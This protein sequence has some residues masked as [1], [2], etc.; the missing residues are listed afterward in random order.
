M[1]LE[2]RS[3]RAANEC[4]SGF[5]AKSHCSG[6]SYLFVVILSSRGQLWS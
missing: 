5:R 2:G 6:T 1:I 4:D 3:A